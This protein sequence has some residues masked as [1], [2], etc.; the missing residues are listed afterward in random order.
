MRHFAS[1]MRKP[2]T[3]V[4]LFATASWSYG[5]EITGP[6]EVAEHKLAKFAIADVTP[7]AKSVWAVRPIGCDLDQV[8]NTLTLTGEPGT[9]EV[10]ATVVDFEARSLER[11]VKLF[12][13]GDGKPTPI[14]PEPGPNPQPDPQPKP[15]TELGKAVQS[16]SAAMPEAERAAL[17]KSFANAA[18][19]LTSSAT[20]EQCEA[21]ARDMNREAIGASRNEW[22]PFFRKLQDNLL[23][24]KAAGQWSKA[25]DCIQAYREIAAGLEA[26][27]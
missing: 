12:E 19:V 7:E 22:L 11:L 6:S 5:A 3:L 9:Y 26:A 18:N 17:A 16:W 2:I 27:Q 15:L 25:S 13:I 10:E 14:P 20:V 4:L 24:R 8:G 23:A 1:I 21:T